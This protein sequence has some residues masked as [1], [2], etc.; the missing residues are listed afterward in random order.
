MEELA[1]FAQGEFVPHTL[2]HHHGL[3]GVEFDL[4]V[5]AGVFETKAH[6]TGDQIEEFVSIGMDLAIMWCVAGDQRC[7][8]RKAVDTARWPAGFLV[9]E[10]GPSGG[11]GHTD[12]LGAQVD[13][14]AGGDL[15]VAGHGSSVCDGWRV[16]S[17]VARSID[18][19]S[20]TPEGGS[21]NIE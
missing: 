2:R 8:D 6:G 16:V 11:A 3:A 9:D 21:G 12:D 5:A 1:G 17:V 19:G 20:R 4:D 10:D 15:V 7:S 18:Q 13:Q 14:L